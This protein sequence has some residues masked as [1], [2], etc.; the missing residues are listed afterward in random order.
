M[1]PKRDFEAVSTK[2]FFPVSNV[3]TLNTGFENRSE[4]TGTKNSAHGQLTIPAP[5]VEEWTQREKKRYRQLVSKFARS[6]LSESE[7]VELDSLEVARAR[8]EDGRSSE[9]I[10]AEFRSRQ[11]YSALLASLKNASITG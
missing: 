9:E 8:F 11:I 1:V 3:V 6:L 4:I 2:P 7:K 10:L 5:G